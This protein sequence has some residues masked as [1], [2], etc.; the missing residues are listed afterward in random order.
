[1]FPSRIFKISE[2]GTHYIARTGTFT[3]KDCRT[4]QRARWGRIRWE[5]RVK[6]EKEEREETVAR[7]RERSRMKR[8]D[9]ES[10]QANKKPL[11]SRK[12]LLQDLSS[13]STMTPQGRFLEGAGTVAPRVCRCPFGCS[14]QIDGRYPHA[15]FCYT[16][17]PRSKHLP[18]DP[19]RCAEA[20][21]IC[22]A[23]DPDNDQD[24]SAPPLPPQGRF[25]EGCKAKE[26]CSTV[27]GSD[28][29][30][31]SCSRPGSS[32]ATGTGPRSDG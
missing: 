25:L 27:G 31:H 1:M 28:E 15:V 13:C 17:G 7:W 30:V 14:R 18:E 19:C 12:P 29:G 3:V 26:M 8:A 5:A 21:A 22:C 16:C 6:R 23:A 4:E 32:P 24:R 11:K 20:G 2:C 9:N 10:N